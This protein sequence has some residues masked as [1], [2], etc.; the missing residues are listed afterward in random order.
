M[1]QLRASLLGIDAPDSSAECSALADDQDLF[2]GTGNGGIDQ[3]P[4]KHDRVGTLKI[5][6][7]AL[8]FR[9]L[10]FMHRTGIAQVQHIKIAVFVV[11]DPAITKVDPYHGI[12]LGAGNTLDVSH[13]SIVDV[14]AVLDLHDFI[15]GSEPSLAVYSVRFTLHRRIDL[16]LETLIQRIGTRFCLLAVWG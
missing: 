4:H 10:G 15:T 7:D 13:I 5:D 6:N 3:R 9:S 8:I 11:D 2:L 1:C 12:G 14:F 16:P